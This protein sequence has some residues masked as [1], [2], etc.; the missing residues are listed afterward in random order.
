MVSNRHAISRPTVQ[1]VRSF[2]LSAFVRAFAIGCHSRSLMRALALL[3]V[4]PGLLTQPGRLSPRDLLR[5]ERRLTGQE[6]AMILS[7]SREALAG[8][9]FQLKPARNTGPQVLMGRDGRPKIIRSAGA[10][11]G[12]LVGPSRSDGGTPAT[13]RWRRDYVKIVEYADQRDASLPSASAGAGLNTNVSVSSPRAPL[14]SST[15][16][17]TGNSP[18]RVTVPLH[19]AVPAFSS[20]V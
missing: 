10:I 19:T 5:L 4:L 11:E 3:V 18:V 8:K 1:A 6:I 16:I 12:G 17:R 13:R 14:A 20:T 7:A 15:T 2:A 9:T